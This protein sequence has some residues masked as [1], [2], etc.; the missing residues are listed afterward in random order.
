MMTGITMLTCG[1][2]NTDPRE[3]AFIA[4]GVEVE[5]IMSLEENVKILKH[6]LKEADSY[7]FK[8]NKKHRRGLDLSAGQICNALGVL[9]KEGV[10]E[11]VGGNKSHF[12]YQVN[13]ELL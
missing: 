11:K 3:K 13:R 9:R 7:Y 5:K 10:L 8:N 1:E 12:L 6:Y 4:K 2:R